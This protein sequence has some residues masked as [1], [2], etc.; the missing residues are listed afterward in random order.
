MY[1]L[2]EKPIVFSLLAFLMPVFVRAIPEILMGSFVTG[3]D[4]LAYYVPNA[5]LWLKNGVG[6]W[7]FLSVAPLFYI[8]LTGIT[9]VGVPI[10]VG[11]KFFGP[12]LLGFLGLA[13]FVYANKTLKWSSRKSLLVA[14]FATLYFVALRISWDMFRSELGLIFL[15]VTLFL[16]G[17]KERSLRNG[18]LLSLAMLSVVLAHQLVAVIMLF[19]ILVT[20]IQSSTEGKMSDVRR[21]VFCSIP[22]VLLFLMMVWANYYVSSDFALLSGYPVQSSGGWQALFGFASYPDLVVDTLGFLLVCYLPLLP[23]LIW[24]RRNRT[25]LELKAW[26]LWVLIALALAIISPVSFFVAL[27]Y[28]WTLLL[29]FPLA[30]YAAEGFVHAR[31]MKRVI[32]CSVLTIL[33]VGLLILPNSLALPYFTIFP[34]YGP[35]SMISNTIPLSDCGDALDTLEWVRSEMDN[36]SLLLV[37]YA[38]A[39]FAVL[40]LERSQLIFYEHDNPAGVANELAENG[41]AHQLYLVWWINGNGWHGQ[42]TVPPVFDEIYRSGR[43]AAFHFD[44]DNEDINNVSR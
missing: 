9:S 36:D 37:H 12:L 41:S 2:V 27:P 29:V 30:F 21:L 35:S 10:V 17:K 22:A 44:T 20:A 23:L 38:F 16:L 5:L 32:V 1:S 3:S 24:G 40:T 26:M 7:N 42:P 18:A 28:R 19:I 13:V 31:R 33:S 25:I 11:L 8:L 4:V 15:F 43:I 34:Y 14:L 6:F 39:G